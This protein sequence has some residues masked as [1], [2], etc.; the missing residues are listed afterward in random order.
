METLKRL[1]GTAL[2]F[3]KISNG[4]KSN[5]IS[6]KNDSQVLKVMDEGMENL[7]P[8]AASNLSPGGLPINKMP[9]SVGYFDKKGKDYY[10]TKSAVWARV[11]SFIFFAGFVPEVWKVLASR[12]GS[13]GLA[14]YRLWDVTN[15]QQ[16][17]YLSKVSDTREI[18]TDSTL[19][20]LPTGDAVV[21]IQVKKDGS[22]SR[23]HFFILG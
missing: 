19:E 17:A 2:S 6:L 7:R 3:F 12:A 8:I 23:I 20:N 15:G 11:S 14:E 16:L 21:E 13:N 5:A 22:K 1:Y 4:D 10:E 9:I 18:L